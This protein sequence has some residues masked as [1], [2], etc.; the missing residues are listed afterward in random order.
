MYC[1][2]SCS[3]SHCS[4]PHPFI[5]SWP[6]SC[7]FNG[8]I[9]SCPLVFFMRAT[10]IINFATQPKCI[11]CTNVAQLDFRLRQRHVRIWICELRTWTLVF[12]LSLF[13]NYAILLHIREQQHIR[14]QPSWSLDNMPKKFQANKMEQD[15][16]GSQAT[17][18]PD[19]TE[20]TVGEQ[21]VILKE[22][23]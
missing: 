18:G 20:T 21:Q 22:L 23:Q 4:A 13:K 3:F 7:G 6:S 12:I 16:R 10:H 5:I 11:F 1:S 9:L 15:T 14:K 8:F 17:A 19:A 2:F